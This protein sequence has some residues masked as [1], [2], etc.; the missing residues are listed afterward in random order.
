[1]IDELVRPAP[2]GPPASSFTGSLLDDDL[3]QLDDAVALGSEPAR[4]EYAE[5]DGYTGGSNNAADPMYAE[6]GPATAGLSLTPRNF[7]LGGWAF[8]GTFHVAPTPM[9]RRPD[10]R[11]RG[12]LVDR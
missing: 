10:P 9:E 3:L 6:I 8:V 7:S 5:V 11:P 4:S 12:R 1:M 2:A